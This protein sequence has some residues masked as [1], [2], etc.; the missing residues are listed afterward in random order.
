MFTVY[1]LYQSR[2]SFKLQ[3][4]FFCKFNYSD[5]DHFKIEILTMNL[6]LFGVSFSLFYLK[7]LIRSCGF[8]KTLITGVSLNHESDCDCES[9]DCELSQW[10]SHQSE[11]ESSQ[12]VLSHWSECEMLEWL[13]IT[14]VTVSPVW[15]LS[16]WSECV[17]HTSDS[18]S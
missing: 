12:W 10:L 14:G 3:L 7:F 11:H 13:W 8:W 4:I 16:H 18:E 9:P 2:L 1:S 5:D 15:L 6:T 17:C